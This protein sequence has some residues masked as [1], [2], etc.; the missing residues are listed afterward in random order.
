[1]PFNRDEVIEKIEAARARIKRD[2]R[3]IEMLE[4]LL[5]RRGEEVSDEHTD[6]EG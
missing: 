5:R 6:L 1:M 3:K 4:A 2:E